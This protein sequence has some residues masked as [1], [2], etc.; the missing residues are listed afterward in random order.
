MKRNLCP[1]DTSLCAGFIDLAK[2]LTLDESPAILAIAG[3]CEI[4]VSAAK[5]RW[6]KY[7]DSRQSLRVFA[8]RLST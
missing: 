1:R 7:S 6:A 3:L 2:A 5:F 4:S 8:T